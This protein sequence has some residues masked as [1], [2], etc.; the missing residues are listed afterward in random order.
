MQQCPTII[1]YT[2]HKMRPNLVLSISKKESL[3]LFVTVVIHRT[4]ALYN[5]RKKVSKKKMGSPKSTASAKA[6]TLTYGAA[7]FPVALHIN[8]M[9]LILASICI[10]F[11]CELMSVGLFLTAYIV[12]NKHYIW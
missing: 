6:R 7:S 9:H 11:Y 4:Q 12:S 5:V 8:I 3:A 2:E 1:S 10:I